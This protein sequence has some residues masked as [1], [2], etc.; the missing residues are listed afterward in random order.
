MVMVEIFNTGGHAILATSSAKKVLAENLKQRAFKEKK[1]VDDANTVAKSIKAMEIKIS[2]K[3]LVE[4]SYL[5]QLIIA[6]FLL[7]L[8]KLAKK[9]RRSLLR[10]LVEMSKDLENI[11]LKFVYIEM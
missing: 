6:M 5:V 10:Y 4:I 8:K 11:M 1:I 2:A 9:S 7:L 3:V